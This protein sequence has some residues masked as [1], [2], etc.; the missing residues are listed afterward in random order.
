M[1]FPPAYANTTAARILCFTG[2]HLLSI[3]T[4]LQLPQK[5]DELVLVWVPKGESRPEAIPETTETTITEAFSRVARSL[6]TFGIV[7]KHIGVYPWGNLFGKLDRFCVGAFN[8]FPPGP[9]HWKHLDLWDMIP[10]TVTELIIARCDFL[11]E[12][13]GDINDKAQSP[14][15]DYSKVVYLERSL[16]RLA[17]CLKDHQ[18]SVQAVQLTLKNIPGGPTEKNITD[19]FQEK[20]LRARVKEFR[21]KEEAPVYDF[22]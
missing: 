5:L 12:R 1:D 4:I 6:I 15:I 8:L 14:D 17:R 2:F 11:L 13:D 19:R 18:H 16:N 10:R 20:F 21:V 9:Q 7:H 22:R 3:S